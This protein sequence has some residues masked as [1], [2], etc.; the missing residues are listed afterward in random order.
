MFS[1]FPNDSS[2]P[3]MDD[4]TGPT[5]RGPNQD[6]PDSGGSIADLLAKM[7]WMKAFVEHRPPP[8]QVFDKQILVVAGIYFFLFLTGICGNSSVIA[9]IVH[10][11]Q[12]LKHQVSRENAFLYI[13]VLCCVDFMVLLSLPITICD[14][15]LGHW[16]FGKWICRLVGMC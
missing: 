5:A 13:I 14:L 6:S 7:P 15:L 3:G 10:I 1:Q 2:M 9:M 8:S 12:T 4:P 11:T 16:M